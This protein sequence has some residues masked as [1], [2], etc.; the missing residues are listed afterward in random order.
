MK[1]GSDFQFEVPDK[2][3]ENCTEKPE[4]F[5]QGCMCTQCPIFTCKEP[6]TDEDKKYM[7]VISAQNFRNDWAKEW[8]TFFKLGIHP[9]LK[10]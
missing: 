6:I 7:P 3:P 10:L 2:C 5:Y 8:E 9:Q 1:I 4:H